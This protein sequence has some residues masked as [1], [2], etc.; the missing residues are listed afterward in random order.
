MTKFQDYLLT[1]PGGFLNEE[2]IPAALALATEQSDRLTQCVV[3]CGC[4]RFVCALQDVA[5]FIGI[6]ER[7]FSTLQGAVPIS[8]AASLVALKAGADYVRDVALC[9]DVCDRLRA[10]Q[11]REQDEASQRARAES[12]TLK[13]A[14]AKRA[15]SLLPVYFDEN[16][17]GGVFDGFS[18]TSDADSG[19]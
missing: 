2:T 10:A 15:P 19:L 16:Q 9:A 6:I 11:K 8:D 1:L 5:H 18:V 4:G 7:D 13:P 3:R 17:C 14:P 12:F